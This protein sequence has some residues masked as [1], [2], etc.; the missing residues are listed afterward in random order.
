MILLNEHLKFSRSLSQLFLA[1][2]LTKA[3]IGFK[4]WMVRLALGN[5]D[6]EQTTGNITLFVYE[7]ESDN[8]WLEKKLYFSDQILK[9]IE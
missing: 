7:D 3:I 9:K 8:P 6:R 5:P 1:S 2:S 4:K